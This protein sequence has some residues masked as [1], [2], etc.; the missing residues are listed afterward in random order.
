[1][2]H[3]DAIQR[4]RSFYRGRRVLVTGHTGF[5]GAWMTAM[6]NYLGA[7]T[8]GFALPPEEGCLY[9]KIDGF[10]LIHSVLGDV[11]NP[12]VVRQVVQNCKPEII[13]HL[14]AKAV[15]KECFEAPLITFD[16]NVMG[17]VNVLEAVLDCPSV[18]SLL[19]IT[20]DK[21][22]QNK[23]DHAL[24]TEADPLGGDDPYS[25]S[26]VCMEFV[27]ES[28][29]RSYLQR[30]GRMVGVATIRASNVLGGGDHVST[31]LIPSILRAIA[32]GRPVELRH[33]Q[34]TRP[35][36]SVLDALNGYLTIGRFLYQHPQEYSG[37]WNI[38]PTK[39]GIRDVLWVV[40]QMKRHYRTVEY[41]VCTPIQVK[42]SETLGL[43]ISKALTRLDWAPAL[44]CDEMLYGIVTFFKQRTRMP[45]RELCRR[46][47]EAFFSC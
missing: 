44:T 26:K 5:K 10:T 8:Y 2:K 14:A 36:Q 23:G 7:D 9:Q 35:W 43:D 41:T 37:A 25:S 34:Q 40:E 1:M 11:R 47:I 28:Y 42:E 16:T 39:D 38:G 46:Q 6:L 27:T 21:V 31:R 19:V 33:P 32:E 12:T 4:N 24:Y 17:T 29:K 15:V 30:D 45:E 13:I 18:K 22:Y 20:S 3:P